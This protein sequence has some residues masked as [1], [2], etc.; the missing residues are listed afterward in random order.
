ISNQVGILIS[1][2]SYNTI[3]GATTGARNVVSGNKSDGVV[4]RFGGTGNQL[5]GN[6]IG[7]DVSGAARLNNLNNGVHLLSAG[8]TVGGTAPGAG[9]VISGNSDDGV[10]INGTDNEVYGNLIGTDASGTKALP[11]GRVSNGQVIGHGVAIISVTGNI[12]GE[13]LPGARNAISGTA[14]DG[15][16]VSGGDA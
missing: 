4:V 3:G 9:N 6:F 10:H 12:I 8:T 7:T 5:L 1:A 15:V 11:N 2:A 13:A 14:N 16:F